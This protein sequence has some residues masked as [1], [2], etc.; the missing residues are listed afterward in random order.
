MT[1]GSEIPKS[2]KIKKKIIQND[3]NS[4]QSETYL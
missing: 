3:Y 2:I 4:K 1:R